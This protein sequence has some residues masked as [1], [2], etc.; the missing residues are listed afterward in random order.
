MSPHIPATP[1]HTRRHTFPHQAEDELL[2]AMALSVMP[3]DQLR[4][5]AREE[6]ALN[7]GL[8]QAMNLDEEDILT[9]KMMHW[10]KQ[11]FFR[12]V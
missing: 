1:P 12:W 10:Y 9:Q 4:A 6:V 2:Q 7:A 5:E 3:L 8:G 11:D